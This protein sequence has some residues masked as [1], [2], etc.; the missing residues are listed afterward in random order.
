M[1]NIC[2][3]QPLKCED[4]L[5]FSVSYHCKIEYLEC[6]TV[7]Q[8]E[9]FEAVTLVS[10]ILWWT[11]SILNCL[12]WCNCVSFLNLHW[13][14]EKNRE[15]TVTPRFSSISHLKDSFLKPKVFS[16]QRQSLLFSFFSLILIVIPLGIRW[17][18][19][20]CVLCASMRS[21][22][23]VRMRACLSNLIFPFVCVR[24]GREGMC[25]FSPVPPLFSPG[26]VWAGRE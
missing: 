1:S 21:Y 19:C 6:W 4:F 10:G 24:S 11:I 12:M 20:E 13:L 18:V 26:K 22:V 7:R 3:S 16:F 25:L 15:N 8:N 5:F 17:G 2:C 14:L 9:Q 23:H